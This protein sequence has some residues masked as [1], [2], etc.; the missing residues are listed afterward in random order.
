MTAIETYPRLV[1]IRVTTAEWQS[2]KIQAVYAGQ[3]L[4]DLVTEAL[5]VSPLTARAFAS[6]PKEQTA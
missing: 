2:L 1:R 3:D 4:T 5:R 6:Q